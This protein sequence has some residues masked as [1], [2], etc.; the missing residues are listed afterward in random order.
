MSELRLGEYLKRGSSL[1]VTR[2]LLVSNHEAD[3]VLRF[4]A[5]TGAF[6]DVFIPRRTGGLAGPSD[7]TVGPDGALYVA[8][9]NSHAVLRFDPRTGRFLGPFVPTG[10][11]GLN[12]PH[13]LVFGPDGN[14]Y[15]SSFGTG[16]ILRYQG[17]NG[18]LLGPFVEPG[19]GGLRE[20]NGLAFG[21]DRHLYVASYGTHQILRYD[22]RSGRFLGEFTSGRAPTMANVLAFGPD[23]HLYVCVHGD[24]NGVYS[25]DGRTGVFRGVLVPRGRGELNMPA[26]I[27]FLR[28]GS[29]IVVGQHSN[30]LLRFHARTGAFM[31]ALG[32]GAGFKMPAQVIAA[33]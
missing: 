28:D 33:P 12:R 10:S 11:G 14:L 1:S 20:P 26:G 4:D 25:Y 9:F 30:N 23:G 31:G 2:H 5:A 13:S 8:S 3:S 7:M 6:K 32:A 17:R 24:E 16:S 27:A 29:L 15:V 18:Q 21:P 19:G 22:G